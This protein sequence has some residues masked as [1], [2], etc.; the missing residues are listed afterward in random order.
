MWKEGTE[1]KLKTNYMLYFYIPLFVSIVVGCFLYWDYLND[2]AILGEKYICILGGTIG[3][4]G[5]CLIVSF[6]GVLFNSSIVIGENGIKIGETRHYK[7]SDIL[8][9]C[10]ASSGNSRGRTTCLVVQFKDKKNIIW[11]YSESV[12]YHVYDEVEIESAVNYWSGRKIGSTSYFNLNVMLKK[13]EISNELYD[14]IMEK[15]DEY[16]PLFRSYFKKESYWWYAPF[17]L[18]VAGVGY[19]LYLYESLSVALDL[20]FL[21]KAFTFLFFLFLIVFLR[22]RVFLSSQKISA[23]SKEELATFFE[24][25]GGTCFHIERPLVVFFVLSLAASLIF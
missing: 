21:F 9:V 12:T 20:S 22:R 19:Y 6:T 13:G 24:V 25:L 23:L 17:V 2:W 14:S 16:F 5:V 11:E 15:S 18:L 4:L 1:L 8:Y 10:L 3:I 7:W